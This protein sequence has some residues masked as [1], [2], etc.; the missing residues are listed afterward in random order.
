MSNKQTSDTPSSRIDGDEVKRACPFTLPQLLSHESGVNL[1]KEGRGYKGNCPFHSDKNASLHVKSYGGEYR[2][3]CFGC[4]ESGDIIDYV[5]RKENFTGS[6]AFIDAVNWLTGGRAKEFATRVNSFAEPAGHEAGGHV[7]D[8]SR[9]QKSNPKTVMRWADDL[10]SKEMRERRPRMELAFDYGKL[11][12]WLPDPEALVSGCSPYPVGAAQYP[13]HSE[14]AT[15]LSDFT[16]LT[17]PKL[18]RTRR[19]AELFGAAAEY[20]QFGGQVCVGIKHRLTPEAMG[21]VYNRLLE[22]GLT[23]EEASDETPRWLARS[24]YTHSIPFEFDANESASR[25]VITEGPGDGARL[26]HEVYSSEQSVESF[27][28]KAHMVAVDSTSSWTMASLPQTTEGGFFDGYKHIILL[29]DPDKAGRAAALT[30]ACLAREQGSDAI[31]RHVILPG[32]SDLCEYFDSGYSVADL[33]QEINHATV[34]AP[35]NLEEFKRQQKGNPP[36]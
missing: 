24:G 3:K 11:R 27:G 21:Y 16:L 18:I 4:G 34:L 20:D 12:G 19:T 32:G 29:L 9:V 8:L 28:A 17:F 26:F 23:P 33:I 10:R 7:L 22:K 35:E 25:L 13:G 6:L 30:I 14:R 36:A 31:I 15:W 2:F 1:R 5:I